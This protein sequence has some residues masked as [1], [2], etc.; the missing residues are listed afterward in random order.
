MWWGLRSAAETKIKRKETS[1]I[2]Q[3][4][5]AITE[6]EPKMLQIK[7]I[8]KSVSKCDFAKT[9]I[10]FVPKNALTSD[11][12][13]KFV[14]LFY[15]FGLRTEFGAQEISFLAFKREFAMRNCRSETILWLISNCYYLKILDNV[16]AS[17]STF[18]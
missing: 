8:P 18:F 5:P 3:S 10:A 4:F 12:A 11:A 14:F 9:E 13:N 16:P 6:S 1:L 7:A 17:G 15:G 2:F